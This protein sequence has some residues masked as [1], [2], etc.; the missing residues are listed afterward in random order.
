M[1]RRGV[2]KVQLIGHIGLDPVLQTTNS[3]KSVTTISVATSETW[4][5]KETQEKLSSTEWH[6]VVFF[7]RLAEVVCEYLK[8]GSKVYIEGKNKTRSWTDKEDITHYVTE[9]IAQELQMLDR[10]SSSSDPLPEAPSGFDQFF[11]C[12]EIPEE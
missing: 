6:R 7:G 9:V 12:D 1:A 10:N 4:K 3:S 2:N 8:K 5:D 11:D